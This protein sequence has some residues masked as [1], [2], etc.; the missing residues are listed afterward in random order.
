M[1]T[2]NNSIIKNTIGALTM[3]SLFGAG[4]IGFMLGLVEFIAWVSV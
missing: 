2:R 4:G 3:V 1:C